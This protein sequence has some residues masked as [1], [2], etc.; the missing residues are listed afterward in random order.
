M[1]PI[2][3]YDLIL[4]LQEVLEEVETQDRPLD[5]RGGF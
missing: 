5:T 2:I 1:K 4:A 3:H